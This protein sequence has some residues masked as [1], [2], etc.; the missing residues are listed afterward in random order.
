MY[1]MVEIEPLEELEAPSFGDWMAG[2]GVGILVG[3]GALLIGIAI[4]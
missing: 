4:T 2:I 3:G 1:S